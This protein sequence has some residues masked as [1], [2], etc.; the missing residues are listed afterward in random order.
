MTVEFNRSS[1]SEIYRVAL[2]LPASA[3]HSSRT[4]SG[5]PG[6]TNF[7]DDEDIAL[8]ANPPPPRWPRIFPSL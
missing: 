7:N 6:K 3:Q 5:E 8:G 4:P 2:S 1:P